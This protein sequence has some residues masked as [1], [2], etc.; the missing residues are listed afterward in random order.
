MNTDELAKQGRQYI[1]PTNNKMC[2][3]NPYT[4]STLVYRNALSNLFSEKYVSIIHNT[5]HF[6]PNLYNTTVVWKYLIQKHPL[7]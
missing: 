3:N 2:H 5:L 6:R 7:V 1:R 4:N